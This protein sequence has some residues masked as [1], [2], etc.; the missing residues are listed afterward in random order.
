[1]KP[2][3]EESSAVSVGWENMHQSGN[4]FDNSWSAF[5][6][7]EQGCRK[8]TV[9]GRG[10]HKSQITVEFMCHIYLFLK[11]YFLKHH[12]EILAIILMNSEQFYE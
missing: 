3:G 9:T 2:G 10:E 11:K 1:M 8:L 4:C 12:C 5:Q 6:Y 7:C